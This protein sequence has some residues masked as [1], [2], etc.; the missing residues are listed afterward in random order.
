VTNPRRLALDGAALAAGGAL[1]LAFAPFGWWPLAVVCPAVMFALWQHATPRVAAWRGWLF[2]IGAFGIGVSWVRESFKF[3]AVPEWLSLLLMA[4]LVGALALYPAL[5]GAVVGRRDGQ[6]ETRRVLLLMPAAWVLVEWLRGWALTGFTWLQVGYAHVDS[7]LAGALPLGGVYLAGWLTA[8]AGAGL[9][10]AWRCGPRAWLA[11]CVAAGAL[12]AG[13]AALETVR[14]SH[15]IGE[16]LEVTIVQGNIAQDQKW[17]P[18]MR[19]PTL[20]RYVGL[21]RERWARSDLVVWPETAVPGLRS[22][23]RPFIEALGAQA[24]E[25]GTR[26]LF[27]VPVRERGQFLNSVEMVGQDAGVYHKRHLVPFGEYLPLA[28]LLRPVVE[29]LGVRVAGFSRGPVDQ[30]PMKVGD[31]VIGLTVCY[32]IAFGAEVIRALPLAALLVTVSNDAWFG[33]SIGPHQHFQ[34]ARARALE[35]ARFLVR[36]TNTGVSAVVGPTGEVLARAPQFRLHALTAS[37]V[38]LAG[39]TPYAR[40]GDWPVIGLV[41]LLAVFGAWPVNRGRSA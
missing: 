27:G 41:V 10:W 30:E 17:R 20:K 35:T 39:M 18:E 22:R 9:V 3:A 33:S 15:P 29:A 16:P 21:S 31:H 23:L 1:S 37:V 32:E 34:I 7:P 11:V 13:G 12:W 5:L 14:W 8:L 38:P 28:W 26:V 4:A 24:R 2:G 36:G 40:A 19:E 25:N 6:H